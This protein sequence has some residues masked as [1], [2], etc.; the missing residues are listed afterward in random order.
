MGIVQ[1]DRRGFLGLAAGLPVLAAAPAEATPGPFP[2]SAELGL[3]PGL[4]HLNTASAGP[5]PNSVLQRVVAAW[6]K[7]ETDPVQM[8][9]W[10]APDSV[11]SDADR[12]REKAAS[13]VGCTAD[14]ILLT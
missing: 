10:V 9:Y 6:H 2:A 8:S 12:V 13:L 14:E 7:I 11:V 5:T 4:I 3:A 1:P